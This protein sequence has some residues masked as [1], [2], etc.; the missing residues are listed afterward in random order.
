VL[1]LDLAIAQGYRAELTYTEMVYPPEDV[2]W[3]GATIDP[4]YIHF[5]DFSHRKRRQNTA[6]YRFNS[7]SN[8]RLYRLFGDL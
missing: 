2:T 6:I 5:A 1:V 7:I 4:S 3:A 8:K